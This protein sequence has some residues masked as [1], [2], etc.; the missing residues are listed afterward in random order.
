MQ[1]SILLSLLQKKLLSA[2]EAALPTP[3]KKNGRDW[4]MK[5]WN[6]A[7]STA[8]R[9]PSHLI[10]SRGVSHNFDSRTNINYK[11][12]FEKVTQTSSPER[13][14]ISVITDAHCTPPTQQGIATDFLGFSN[15]AGIPLKILTL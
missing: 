2:G 1:Q 4:E 8:M 10:S 13:G 7:A 15:K 9:P 11:H 14:A 5:S 6:A 3:L 12:N